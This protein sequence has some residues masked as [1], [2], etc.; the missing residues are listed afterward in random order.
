MNSGIFFGKDLMWAQIVNIIFGL[1][2]MVSPVVLNFDGLAQTQCYWTGPLVI[3]ISSIAAWEF[4]RD[5][6]LFNLLIS[7]WLLFSPFL[8]RFSLTASANSLIMGMC[9]TFFSL[10]KGRQ[11]RS[12]AGG[13][14]SLWK[15]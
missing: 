13:W 11:Y 5:V 6:R 4:N 9:I 12:Y 2:I 14:S 3:T 1:W 7:A 8:F 15:K 10:V